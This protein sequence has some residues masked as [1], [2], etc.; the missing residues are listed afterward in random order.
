MYYLDLVGIFAFAVTGALKAKGRDLHLF[1][2]LFFREIIS[3]FGLYKRI[4]KKT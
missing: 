3:P 2:A 1:G 4:F